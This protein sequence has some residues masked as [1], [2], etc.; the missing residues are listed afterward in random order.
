MKKKRRQKRLIIFAALLALGALLFLFFTNRVIQQRIKEHIS[1][2]AQLQKAEY[3]SN[4][5]AAKM[6]Y[7]SSDTQASST[8]EVSEENEVDDISDQNASNA[9]KVIKYKVQPGD[10]LT[11]IAEQHNT[12]VEQIMEDND[13]L[14]GNVAS[15]VTLTIKRH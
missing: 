9:K 15:G 11:M 13:L 5:Q 4:K 1:P 7:G 12:T 3:E 10:S 8:R 2:S 6:R 14:D